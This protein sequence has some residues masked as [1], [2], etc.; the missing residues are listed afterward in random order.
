LQE[1]T[2]VFEIKGAAKAA[3]HSKLLRIISPVRVIRSTCR[4][5][6]NAEFTSDNRDYRK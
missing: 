4:C 5:V 2:K 1:N 3:L 6:G